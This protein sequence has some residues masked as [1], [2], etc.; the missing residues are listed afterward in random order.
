[1]PGN[2][3]YAIPDWWAVVGT[4]L[5]LIYAIFHEELWTWWRRPKIKISIQVKHPDCVKTTLPKQNSSEF[6]SE[7]Y[8]F[9]LRVQNFG[10]TTA[11]AVEVYAERL[12][13]QLDDGSLEDVERFPP[14]NLLWA[15]VRR[16]TQ[17]ISPGLCRHCDLGFI[18]GP[19]TVADAI[20]IHFDHTLR[21]SLDLEVQP[22]HSGFRIAAGSYQ[23]TVVVG[24]T[25]MRP[26]RK[27]INLKFSGEWHTDENEMFSQGIP[28][29]V[30]A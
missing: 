20:D 1:M 30:I 28:I 5:T 27:V 23:L 19:N 16:S 13:H 8:R 21:L 4:L 29:E 9:R 3:W 24:A 11:E 14:M 12:Q 22:E 17:S 6:Y 7:C 25:N 26:Q 10:E 15:H 2:P 18:V